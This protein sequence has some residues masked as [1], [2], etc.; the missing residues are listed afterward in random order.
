MRVFAGP[1][2]SG[3][4]TIKDILPSDLLG[5]YLNP[6]DLEKALR[7]SPFLDLNSFQLTV[8]TQ[9]FQD[10]L[11]ASTLIRKLGVLSTVQKI[12]VVENVLDVSNVPINAYLASVLVDF[13]RSK[14]IKVGQPFTFETVMSAADKLEVLKQAKTRGFRNYLYYIATEDPI[15]NV[16]RV[17]HRV[18]SGGHPVPEDK[19]ISRYYRSLDHLFDAIQLTERAYLFDNSGETRVWVAEVT[20]GK[21]IELKTKDVPNWFIRYVE[22]KIS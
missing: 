22:N 14:L 5:Y 19:I 11:K 4:S 21:K 10:F 2:G 20:G 3:K 16:A 1:N 13:L 12:S 6:D 8:S 9:A 15:I 7:I 18:N 17:K